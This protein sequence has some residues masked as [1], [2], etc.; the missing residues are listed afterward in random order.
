MKSWLPFLVGLTLGEVLFHR[1]RVIVE[2]TPP[3]V[4][5]PTSSID[6]LEEACT[7]QAQAMGQ[8]CRMVCD[9]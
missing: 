5:V 6:S 2:V 1:P 9:G 8:S 4:A 7:T 3:A